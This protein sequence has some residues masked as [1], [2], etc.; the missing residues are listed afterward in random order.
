MQIIDTDLA[1]VLR[2]SAGTA[3]FDFLKP[4][5]SS[6]LP[7]E[8]C[9]RYLAYFALFAMRFFGHSD[10]GIV[11]ETGFADEGEFSLFPFL[12]VVVAFDGCHG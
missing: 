5:P 1:H 10:V 12:F 8:D 11:A 2:P 9:E 4:S 6:G 7:G 3:D